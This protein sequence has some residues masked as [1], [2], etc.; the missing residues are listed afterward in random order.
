MRGGSESDGEGK[1]TRPSDSIAFWQDE[2]VRKRCMQL[3]L[4]LI[5]SLPPFPATLAT[6]QSAAVI[7]ECDSL[8]DSYA[9]RV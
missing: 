6:P 9:S 4:S 1:K 3:G 8:R 5:H 7:A 2:E